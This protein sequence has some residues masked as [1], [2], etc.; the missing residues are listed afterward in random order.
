MEQ[1][2]MYVHC[3]VPVNLILYN[4]SLL[5]TK[6]G[7]A[8]RFY[9]DM[10]DRVFFVLLLLACHVLG[11]LVK[12]FIRAEYCQYVLA[13]A[14]THLWSSR[15]YFAHSTECRFLYKK[16]DHTKTLYCSKLGIAQI[17]F[18]K[19]SFKFKSQLNH[20]EFVFLLT[21]LYRLGEKQ[22]LLVIVIW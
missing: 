20:F 11:T 4:Y 6:S 17:W 22:L 5:D 7:L 13:L 16:I 14:W 1:P 12:R 21:I 2:S 18:F 8:P 15:V 10:S 3:L 9:F 19:V